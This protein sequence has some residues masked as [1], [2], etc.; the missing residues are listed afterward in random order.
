MYDPGTPPIAA[1]KKTIEIDA[2][3]FVCPAVLRPTHTVSAGVRQ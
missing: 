3:L 1:A 2:A